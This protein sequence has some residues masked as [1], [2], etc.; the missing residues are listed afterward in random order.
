MS[1]PLSLCFLK[2]GQH[3]ARDPPLPAEELVAF[4]V[5]ALQ[6]AT[7]RI[8]GL[9][10]QG[11][12][13]LNGEVHFRCR[14]VSGGRRRRRFARAEELEQFTAWQSDRSALGK[15]AKGGTEIL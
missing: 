14:V 11:G 8:G 7:D 10:E 2:C 1:W 15:R 3:P 4:E 12:D 9:V 13:L 5:P 6:P